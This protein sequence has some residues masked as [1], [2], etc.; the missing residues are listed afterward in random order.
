MPAKSV[1]ISHSSKNDG[2]VRE[3]RQ[4]LE[5]L[6]VETWAD[7]ERL[8]GGG[9]LAP[10]IQKAIDKADC[11]LAV[12]SLDAL[13][14]EW[15]NWPTP[16]SKS[17]K[18]SPCNRRRHADLLAGRRRTQRTVD[19]LPKWGRLLYDTLDVAAARE[20]LEAWKAAAGD[21]RFTVKIDKN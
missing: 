2:I 5:A 14:S 6:G 13:N 16:R 8:A 9:L 20:P 19:A 1:F 11:F 10:E 17:A 15:V 7:S 18:A 4:T 3:I 21:R 12:V